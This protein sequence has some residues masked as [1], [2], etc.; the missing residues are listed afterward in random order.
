MSDHLLELQFLLYNTAN[1][2][3]VKLQRVL[4]I[5]ARVVSRSPRF[6]AQ[7]LF[8]ALAEYTGEYGE[9]HGYGKNSRD[10]FSIYVV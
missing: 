8:I 7:C 1:N 5:L 6:L 2:E 3:T 4:N 9:D 10:M